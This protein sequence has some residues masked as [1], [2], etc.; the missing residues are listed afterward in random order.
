MLPSLKN[1]EDTPALLRSESLRALVVWVGSLLSL[2]PVG[3]LL[4][5]PHDD[6]ALERNR[7]AADA[8]AE[9]VLFG[10]AAPMGV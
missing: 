10:H 5:G 8:E 2:R 4:D 7:V 3:P 1:K 6:T 9:P